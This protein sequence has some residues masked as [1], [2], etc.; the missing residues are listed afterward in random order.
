MR[1]GVRIALPGTDPVVGDLVSPATVAR[2]VEAR[3]F[4]SLWLPEH[5][6]IP[7]NHSPFPGGG[8]VP[9]MY[10]N[11]YDPFLALTA[12]AGATSRLRLGTGVCLL[13][14]RDAIVLAKEIASLDVLSGGRFELGIGFG[15]NR[16]E[17]EHHGVR[18]RDRREAVRDRV[19]AMKALWTTAEAEHHGDHV[20]FGPSWSWPKPVQLPHP[21]VLLGARAG[22]D[23]FAAIASYAD[24]WLPNVPEDLAELPR[25]HRAFED[26]GR[27]P[28][29]L[30]ITFYG[31]TDT[32]PAWLEQLA[33]ARVG[34]V[35][36]WL[37]SA[38][39]EDVV[40][41]LDRISEA[42]CRTVLGE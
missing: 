18:W 17:L 30:A 9:D 28:A 21:P 5:T 25:L 32:S 6:H 23:T 7:L 11:V 40:R 8:P 22:D 37:P 38:R 29:S 33:N 36:Y 20:S 3:G 27:D 1:V 31:S 10:R 39:R 12:A 41:E 4:E 13:A 19:L 2:D 24:G 16:P 14:Q 34:R 26:A 15:W 42:V 35:V